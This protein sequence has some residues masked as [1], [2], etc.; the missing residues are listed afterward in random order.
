MASS[1]VSSLAA[2]I[3]ELEPQ[4]CRADRLHLWLALYR[5]LAEVLSLEEHPRLC[6]WIN[7]LPDY[8]EGE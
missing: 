7:A 6:V 2:A 3:C 8:R 4:L 1:S 5:K